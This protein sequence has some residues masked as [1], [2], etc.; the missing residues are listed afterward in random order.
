[1]ISVAIVD[2]KYL[3]R[4]LL[5]QPY[6]PYAKSPVQNH[7]RFNDLRRWYSILSL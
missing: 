4:S 6:S 1:M 3:L 7:G 2:W 5:K